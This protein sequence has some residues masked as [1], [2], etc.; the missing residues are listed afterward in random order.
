[1]KEGLGNSQRSGDVHQSCGWGEG[2]DYTI[3][4]EVMKEK[5]LNYVLKSLIEPMEDLKF[6]TYTNIGLKVTDIGLS[7]YKSVILN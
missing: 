6:N 4:E 7:E 3:E 2:G 1:M 5:T